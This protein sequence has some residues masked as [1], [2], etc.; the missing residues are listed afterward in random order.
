MRQW[1]AAAL[2][3]LVAATFPLV[4][5]VS[6]LGAAA[7]VALA[8]LARRRRRGTAAVALAGTAIGVLS[9]AQALARNDPSEPRWFLGVAALLLALVAGANRGKATTVTAALL[10]A[11]AINLLDINTFYL[12]A[13]PCWFVAAFTASSQ[14]GSTLAP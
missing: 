3:L 13:V 2:A 5:R 10:G 9:A 7:V 8:W 6:L 4:G 12:A 1:L 14:P 11:V